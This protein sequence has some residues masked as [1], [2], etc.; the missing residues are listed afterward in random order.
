MTSLSIQLESRERER[1][2]ILNGYYLGGN[3]ED[4][5]VGF[6]SAEITET[7]KLAGSNW[8]GLCKPYQ[9]EPNRRFNLHT[10]LLFHL[11]KL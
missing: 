6:Y 11:F 7:R 2:E 10:T 1:T 4:E 3:K 5:A 8:I 9:A